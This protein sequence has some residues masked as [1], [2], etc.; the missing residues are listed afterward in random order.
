VWLGLLQHM[1]A[2]AGLSLLTCM[3]ILVIGGAA[4]PRA[5]IAKFQQ[6]HIVDVSA[7]A[8]RAT[9]TAA[10]KQTAMIISGPG[11]RWHGG[12]GCEG[13]LARSKR[14]LVGGGIRLRLQLAEGWPAGVH[15]P[16]SRRATNLHHA[17]LPSS[18]PAGPPHVGNDRKNCLLAA[19]AA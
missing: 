11:S 7:L 2:A 4:A 10:A 1:D 14:M 16:A 17:H 18:C 6:Q 9:A 19:R 13:R 12:T 5:M 15:R 8:L 3:R